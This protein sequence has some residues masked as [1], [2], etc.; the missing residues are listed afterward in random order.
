MISLGGGGG[1]SWWCD[2]AFPRAAVHE[3][4]DGVSVLFSECLEENARFAAV[5]DVVCFVHGMQE[6]RAIVPLAPW[7]ASQGP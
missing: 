5:C 6:D 4:N 2:A 7:C 1:D 3:A